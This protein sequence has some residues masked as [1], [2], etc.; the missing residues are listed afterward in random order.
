MAAKSDKAIAKQ[1][2]PIAQGSAWAGKWRSI[3]EVS[4]DKAS[5]S[6]CLICKSA[7]SSP[8]A[9]STSGNS[10]PRPVK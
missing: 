10:G 9:S 6:P 7:Q 1:R 8:W 3:T 2:Q 5:S 4:T